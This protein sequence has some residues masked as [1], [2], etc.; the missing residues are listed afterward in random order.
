[1]YLS[2]NKKKYWRQTERSQSRTVL[3][4]QNVTSHRFSK[5]NQSF[6]NS[7]STKGVKV[8]HLDPR[9][10]GVELRVSKLYS[11]KIQIPQNYYI[12]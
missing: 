10:G 2:T 12:I 9:C 8:S 4:M 6:E 5:V 3:F 1:M 11:N 7:R